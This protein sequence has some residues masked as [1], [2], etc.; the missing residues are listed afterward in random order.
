MKFRDEQKLF[1]EAQAI[2][3]QFIGKN[4][5]MDIELGLKHKKGKLTNEV[6]L[7]FKVKEKKLEM[8]VKKTELIPKVLGKFKTDVL[9][10]VIVQHQPR[11]VDSQDIVRPLI[12]GIQIQ[13]DLYIN[14]NSGC[15]TMGC[16]YSIQDYIL[17]ITN[18]HVLYGS[19]YLSSTYITNSYVGK[20]KVFQNLNLNN[21]DY[22]IGIASKFFDSNLDYATFEID[23]QVQLDISQNIN[24]TN[25]L[26]DSYIFP[27][28]NMPVFKSGAKTGK[29]FGIIDG[30]SCFNRSELSIHI[31]TNYH[32]SNDVISDYGDSGSLWMLN[33][34]ST[35]LKPVAL[36][37]GGGETPQWAKAKS[38]VSIIVSIK[39]KIQNSKLIV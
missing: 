16:F 12:G 13:S 6:A 17:G 18:F 37:Y 7:R 24:N 29:T 36:H 8:N 30:R 25:G 38:F 9:S 1:K 10:N 23:Q 35:K 21:N 2:A 20:L 4:G 32:N 39:N 26:L 27:Q 14:T 22:K 15:G 31:D 19:T 28:I 34:S 5:I 3:K 33:D 11:I